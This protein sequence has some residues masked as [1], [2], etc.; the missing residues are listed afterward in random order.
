MTA[1][2]YGTDVAAKPAI[3]HPLG[4]TITATPGLDV[5]QSEPNGRSQ[6]LGASRCWTLGARHLDDGT[7]G[8]GEVLE[9][10]TLADD[11]AV[12]PQGRTVEEGH[13]AIAD[14]SGIP[15]V[16]FPVNLR[17]ALAGGNRMTSVLREVVALRRGAGKLSPNEYFFYRL[18]DPSLGMAEKRRFVGKQA[19]HPMHMACN[20][21][22]WYAAAADKLLFQAVMAGAGL[23]VPELLAVTRRPGLAGKVPCLAGVAGIEGFLRQPTLYPLFAKPIDSKYSLAVLN[24]EALDTALDRIA[25]RG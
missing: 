22:G 8:Q 16:D 19:Q 21:T 3:G 11:S 14:L 17:A 10:I 15:K 23:P 13:P 12:M 18:W 9:S 1:G 24:A 7:I 5:R 2:S 20:H 6:N 25:V 4:E